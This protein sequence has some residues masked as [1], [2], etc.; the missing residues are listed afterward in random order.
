M[1]TTRVAV[2]H[3]LWNTIK[4]YKIQNQTSRKD[5]RRRHSWSSRLQPR[6]GRDPL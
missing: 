3:R 6:M 1:A 5:F 4:F 2:H